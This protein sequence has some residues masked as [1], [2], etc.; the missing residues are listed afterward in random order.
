MNT[1]LRLLHK[2]RQD[3]A[4]LCLDIKELEQEL[5]KQLP[6]KETITID[7]LRVRST[8]VNTVYL[9]LGPIRDTYPDVYNTFALNNE[10]S[11]IT[12]KEIS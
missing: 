3:K 7:N 1:K 8:I 4:R 2:L 6:L 5:V 9:P 12:I 11:R 10:Y